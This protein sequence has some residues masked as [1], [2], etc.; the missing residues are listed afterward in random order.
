MSDRLLKVEGAGNDFLLG[1]GRWADRLGSEPALVRRLCDRRHGIG[2]DG[3]LAVTAAGA[4]RVRLRYRNAD[5]GEARFCANGTRCA[6]RAAVEL[7][8]CSSALTVATG[9]GEI[10]AR[11][12]G[13]AV[14]LE[15]PPPEAAPCRLR[16]TAGDAATGVELYELGVP[17]LVVE[18]PAPL[19]EIALAALAAPLRADPALGPEG[20]NVNLYEVL[21]DG[22]VAV[23]SWERG[24][25]G[26]TA[27]CGSGIV[28]VALA[29]MAGR[30]LRELRLRAASG[31][32]LTVEALAEPPRCATRLSGPA[33]V[34][35]EIQ[36]AAELLAGLESGSR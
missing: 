1:I 19:A 35:A 2:A 4:G 33:R 30:G 34:V 20:A 26:E 5:G 3:T 32:L 9:W 27:C 28:A 8:G 11:V 10:P 24:V 23:R 13:A 15:L 16:L 21:A 22:V 6:A 18:A 14:S 29:V 36:P 31:D 17:H 12:T 25:E 7:L